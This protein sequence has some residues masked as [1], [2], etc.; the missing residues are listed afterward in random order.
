MAT[1]KAR[2]AY[3]EHSQVIWPQYHPPE[4]VDAGPGINWYLDELGK[5][6]FTYEEVCTAVD[7]GHYSIAKASG[8][9]EEDD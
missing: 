8:W 1:T 7:A 9:L 3:C 2:K 6:W 4:F 5:E